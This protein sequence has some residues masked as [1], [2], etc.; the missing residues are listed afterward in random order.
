MIK[1][2]F[3]VSDKNKVEAV[4]QNILNVLEDFDYKDIEIE[5]VNYADSILYYLSKNNPNLEKI[6]KL[7]DLGVKIS[8][9]SNSMKKNEVSKDDFV[10]DA[11]VVPAGIGHI[12]RLQNSGYLYIK[13]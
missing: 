3:D 1:V 6:N 5:L 2:V 11:N 4:F 7:L 8:V 10:F 12:I 9:C 13:P